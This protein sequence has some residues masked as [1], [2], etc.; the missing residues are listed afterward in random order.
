MSQKAY[1]ETMRGHKLIKHLPEVQLTTYLIDY[2][3]TAM[4]IMGQL[5]NDPVVFQT[6]VEYVKKI[7]LE[8]YGNYSIDEVQV[9]LEMGGLGQ[10]GEKSI[11]SARTVAM[12]FKKYEGE[13]RPFYVRSYREQVVL[14]EP[15]KA[16]NLTPDE[17][18]EY[19]H[20]ALNDYRDNEVLYSFTYD[21][22]CNHGFTNL[23]EEKKQHYLEL[24]DREFRLVA[25]ARNGEQP[26]WKKLADTY[27][28]ADSKVVAFAKRL[29]LKDFFKSKLNVKES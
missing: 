6:T 22:L 27:D 29:A 7:M 28:N 18:R 13:I 9:V 8:T 26:L 1:N 24:A 2:V 17:S 16:R 20:H 4:K 12:W 25:A 23:F 3:Q 10:L 5:N 21:I 19:F 14:P 15:T 11:M